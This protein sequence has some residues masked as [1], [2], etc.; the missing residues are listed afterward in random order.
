M[1][2]A[3]KSGKVK[4]I[5]FSFH[6]LRND[7]KRITDAYDW[8]FCQIQ[9]NIL[10]EKNQ[11]GKEGL[12]YAWSRNIG[13]IVMEPLRGGSL[14]GKL[15]SEVEKIYTGS[16]SERSNAEWS[17]RWI[18]NH[19]GVI[20]VLSGMNSMKQLEENLKTASDSEINSMSEKELATVNNAAEKFREL[21][22]V[23]CTGC[24]YCMPCPKGV[25]IPRAFSFYNNK[26]LFKQ[27]FISRAMYLMQLGSVH[28]RKTG[29]ASQCVGCGL[30]IK[31]CPQHIQIPE[32]LKKVEREFEGK[33]TTKPIIW[34]LGKMFR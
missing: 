15:P 32:N 22:M 33:L 7:F 13:V 19:P 23:P 17:L 29:L 25:D 9:Y 34:L 6:G 16:N 2:R 3:K 20:T 14:A 21:M 5:G 24:Q 27:G 18:W 11:A 31:H 30:C 10:D 8:E 1:N 26:H 28:D 12:D 4:H